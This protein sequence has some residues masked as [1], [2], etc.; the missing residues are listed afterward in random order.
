MFY[1]SRYA[2]MSVCCML[3]YDEDE[4]SSHSSGANQLK[5]TVNLAGKN[6]LLQVAFRN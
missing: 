2:R 1:E 5:S 3:V 6:L 4:E